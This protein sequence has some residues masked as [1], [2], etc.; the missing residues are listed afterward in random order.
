MLNLEALFVDP[1]CKALIKKLVKYPEAVAAM[2]S[3]L[4]VNCYTYWRENKDS[5]LNTVDEEMRRTAL[6]EYEELVKRG[7]L[8]IENVRLVIV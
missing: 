3:Y 7:A 1:D 2:E 8:M 5:I 4:N 6:K